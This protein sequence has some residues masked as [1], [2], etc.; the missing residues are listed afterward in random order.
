MTRR[1]G[2]AIEVVAAIVERDD[3]FLVTRRLRG[4]HLAGLWE[5]PG[6]KCEAGETHETCLAREMTEELGVEAFV[7]DEL[8]S[9]EHTYPERTVRLHFRRCRII[10]EPQPLL[11]QEIRWVARDQLRSLEFPAADAKLLDRLLHGHEPGSRER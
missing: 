6:G 2:D 10:G 5:F 8:L 9:V 1:R 3:C 7:E 4:T 11:N